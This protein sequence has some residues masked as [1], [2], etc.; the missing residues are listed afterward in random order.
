M[1]KRKLSSRIDALERQVAEIRVK[2]VE[3]SEFRLVDKSGRLRA[4]L[5]MTRTGPRLA[6]LDEDGTVALETSLSNDGPS[7]RLADQ[8]G[9]TRVFLGAT[10]DASR[11]GLADSDGAQRVFLGVSAG[12]K[13]AVTVYDSEQRKVWEAP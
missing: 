2:A 4:V 10:R 1:A 8:H 11:I 5:E 7:I 12:G 13:P 6:L 9:N 3:A